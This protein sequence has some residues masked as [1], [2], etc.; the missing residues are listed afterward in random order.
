MERCDSRHEMDAR[1]LERQTAEGEG[2]WHNSCFDVCTA[3]VTT[4]PAKVNLKT[5]KV[6][7]REGKACIGVPRATEKSP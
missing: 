7:T 2:P 4:G 6:E 5:F 3:T 1:V